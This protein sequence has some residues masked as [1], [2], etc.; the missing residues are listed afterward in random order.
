[1]AEDQTE[2]SQKTEDPTPRRLEEARK[3][4][5][6]ILSRE[7]N[8]WVILFTGAMLLAIAAPSILS[9]LKSVLTTFIARPETLP[10][11]PHGLLIVGQSLML[12][13][14]RILFLPLMI[15]VVAAIA[16]PFAQIGPLF[17]VDPMKPDISKISLIKGFQRLFSLRAIM[18]FVKGIA[19]LTIVG[20]VGTLIIMPFFAG[21]EHFAGLDFGQGLYE[22]HS[23]VLRLMTGVLA[24][25]FVIAA[26]DYMYQRYE[27]IKK[28]RMSK[29]E[30]REE[31]RQSE[32]DPHVKAR[33]RELR[34]TR[35][36]QRMMQAVPEADVVITNPTHY[37]VAL[38]Y[39]TA[40]MEAPTM[41]AKGADAV[42][43]RIKDVAREHSVPIVENAPLARAL[44][45][46][47]DIDQTIPRDQYKAVAEVISYVFKL[48]RQRGQ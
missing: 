22:L 19:K 13:V 38:K 5:Q 17:T 36:R 26:F 10:T 15:L 27:H 3:R 25:L 28:L 12:D 42:A 1:M 40:N 46:A 31:F 33:L 21:I 37:A 4:G 24:I 20:V 6:V 2:D 32:G 8:N 14:G 45:D 47:M 18:E 9:N 48:K 44:F 30:L 16:A 34:E 43:E 7:I 29:Q 23:L 11:D 39:D 41:V 35:A